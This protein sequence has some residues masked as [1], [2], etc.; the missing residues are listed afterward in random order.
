VP[1]SKG[2]EG[3]GRGGRGKGKGDEYT[4]Q[5]GIGAPERMRS[6]V[7]YLGFPEPE[8]ILLLLQCISVMI[9]CYDVFLFH[10]RFFVV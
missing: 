3:K 7:S 6:R 10:N 1:T 9:R 4:V 2:R 5:G 8:Y